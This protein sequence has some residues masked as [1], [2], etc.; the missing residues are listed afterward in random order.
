[1]YKEFT[2]ALQ[3]KDYQGARMIITAA[4]K[5]GKVKTAR[6]MARSLDVVAGY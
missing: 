6:K 1:M 3:Q 4:L 2:A 5:R